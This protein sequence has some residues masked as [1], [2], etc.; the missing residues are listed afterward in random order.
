LKF[1]ADFHSKMGVPQPSPTIPTLCPAM[2]PNFSEKL[3]K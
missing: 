3:T 2:N 1:K